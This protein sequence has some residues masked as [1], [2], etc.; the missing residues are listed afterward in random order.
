MNYQRIHDEIIERALRRDLDGK[1]EVHHILPK[2]MGGTDGKSN[3]VALTPREHVLIHI[4]LYKIHRT[5][6]MAYAVTAMRMNTSSQS[7]P[8]SKA[9]ANARVAAAAYYSEN[10]SGVNH[11]WYGKRHTEETKRK[12]REAA[13]GRKKDPDGIEKTAKTKRKKVIATC[14]DTGST[15]EFEGMR[16]AVEAGYA[17]N[18]GSISSACRGKTKTHNGYSWKYAGQD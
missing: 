17:N 6:Q 11:N 12:Q 18:H 8:N 2:C 4:L 5:G 1:V 16:K 13:L 3:L 7:R 10:F 9:I 15:F 14:I